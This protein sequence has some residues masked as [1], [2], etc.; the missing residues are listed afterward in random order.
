MAELVVHLQ[1]WHYSTAEG[2]SPDANREFGALFQSIQD[3]TVID[4]EIAAATELNL[5]DTYVPVEV[6]F[7]YERLEYDD[8]EQYPIAAVRKLFFRTAP[9][10]IYQFFIAK[11]STPHNMNIFPVDVEEKEK[12]LYTHVYVL[13]PLQIP[14]NTFKMPDTVATDGVQDWFQTVANDNTV[15][16][17]PGIL[18]ATVS[19]YL[20]YQSNIMQGRDNSQISSQIGAKYCQVFNEVLPES[21]VQLRAMLQ[22]SG[23]VTKFIQSNNHASEPEAPIID[24]DMALRNAGDPLRE[25][26]RLANGMHDK[27]MQLEKQ[28]T[29]ISNQD[30][31]ELV[32]ISSAAALQFSKLK[33]AVRPVIK[34]LE[35]DYN[36]AVSGSKKKVAGIGALGAG[37]TAVA[38]VA[39]L[40]WWNPVGWA[41]ALGACGIGGL[42]AGG[43][44]GAAG[45]AVG[46]VAGYKKHRSFDSKGNEACLK[47]ERV[48]EFSINVKELDDCADQARKAIAIIFC[49]QVMQKDLNVSLPEHERRSI[50]DTLAVDMDAVS[51]SAYTKGVIRDRISEFRKQNEKLCESIKMVCQ[52]ANVESAIKEKRI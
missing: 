39:A 20:M 38:V 46:G 33:Q 40:C 4:G 15:C 27:L 35:E 37:V 30:L 11:R 49:D 47:V 6:K 5:R 41:A 21:F 9:Q 43:A 3:W 34:F 12:S 8:P 28:E 31:Y 17:V 22:Q 18:A 1:V 50:L 26:A 10:F 16:D 51:S 23:S 52:D 45:V 44:G 14:I 19:L 2:R 42:G 48:K 25:Y 13:N 24:L 36:T 32:Q 7:R 29:A